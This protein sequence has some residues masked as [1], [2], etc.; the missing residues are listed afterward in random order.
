MRL[1]AIGLFFLGCLAMAAADHA[2][3]GQKPAIK[4]SSWWDA[5]ARP[6]AV[7]KGQGKA[8]A[9]VKAPRPQASG[10]PGASAVEP[11]RWP[12]REALAGKAAPWVIEVGK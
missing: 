2:Q 6:A 1:A 5:P 4:K 8:A 11:L 7:E 3:T 9:P 10:S 12:E